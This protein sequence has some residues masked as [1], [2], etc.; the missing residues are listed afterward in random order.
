MTTLSGTLLRTVLA[1]CGALGKQCAPLDTLAAGAVAA[2]ADH[3]PD[4]TGRG[5]AAWLA[6][7]TQESAWLRTTTEYGIWQRY[8]P[9]IGRT[10]EQVTWRANYVEFGRWCKTRGLVDDELVF[11]QN[12][13]TLSELRWAWL[14]GVWYFGARRLWGYANSGN[15]QAVAN[16]VNRG[17]ATLEGY[18]S[19]WLTRLQCYR[20]YLGVLATPAEIP[21][22][23]VGGPV[24]IA[25]L[26]EWVG[27]YV[28]GD[29]GARTIK[30]LQR[31][32]GVPVDGNLGQ[33]TVRALQAKVGAYGDGVW[34]PATTRALQ[35]Y[36]NAHR[37][38]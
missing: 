26:Q 36:L 34:G 7:Q 4:R 20:A 18:P 23:G 15:F 25:R 32:L 30:A 33:R 37:E 35:S 3:A 28:D 9:Y 5:T 38:G 27:V 11:A 24:S 29:Q 2:L 22:D 12:P 19:G 13:R 21:V 1:R 31:W 6:T 17:S 14:G 10:F 16:A 8:A